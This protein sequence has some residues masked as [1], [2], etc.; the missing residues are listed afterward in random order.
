M[1]KI[2]CKG[3]AFCVKNK[4]ACRQQ[5]PAYELRR[6]HGQKKSG[7]LTKPDFFP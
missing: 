4:R 3:K 6:R 5:N 1:R 2:R 7:L